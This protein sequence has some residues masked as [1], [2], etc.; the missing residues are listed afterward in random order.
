MGR[1]L[2]LGE[3]LRASAQTFSE[4]LDEDPVVGFAKDCRCWQPRLGVPHAVDGH[5]SFAKQAEEHGPLNPTPAPGEELFMTEE[6]FLRL[7]RKTEVQQLLCD[8]D[9][10]VEPWEASRVVFSI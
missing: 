6:E 9:V 7:I 5:H 4:G 8:M 3:T 1:S 2:G 10:N